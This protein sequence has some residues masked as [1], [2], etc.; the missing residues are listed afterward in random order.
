MRTLSTSRPVRRAVLGAAV[1]TALIVPTGGF[2]AAAAPGNP[3]GGGGPFEILDPQY[4]QNPDT[5]TWDDW[6]AVPGRDWSDPTVTGSERNFDIAL[7]TLDYPDQPFVVTQRP[8]STVFGNPQATASNIPREQVAQFYTDFLNTPNDLNKGHTLHEYWMQ[9]S[10]GRYGVDL[11]GFGPYQL[12][13][14]SYQYGI[15]N[16][17]NPG[18]CPAGEQCARNI[19]TDG[20]GAWRAAV[21]DEV[22]DSYELVFILSA[23]QD[24]SSTWQEFGQMTFQTK[25]DVPDAWGPPDPNLPNWARTRYVEWTSWKAASTIWPNAGGGS[26]T[27]AESSGMGVYAHELSHLLT[28]GDNYNNPYGTPLRRTY[29]GI[30]G[31][32]SRG[33]FNGPGGPHTRWQIPPTNGGAMGSLH[34]V[35]DKI[36]IGLVGEEHILRLSREALASSGIVVADV[37]AR[38]VDAGR[39]GLTG[40]IVAMDRDRS[41][42]C[43]TSADPLCDGGNFNNYTVEVVDRMGADSF[44]PDAG[45]LLSKTKNADSAPFVWV[46]DANPQDIDMVDFYRPDGTP[47]KITM[48]DYRQLSDALFHAGTGSGSEFEYVD[49]ANRLHFYILDLRRDRTGVLSYTVAVRSLDGAGGPSAHGVALTRGTVTTPNSKPTNRGV[50]CSFTLTNT[51]SFSAGGQQH[52]EDV[53]AYLD[54]DVY[55]LSTRAAGVGWRSDLPNALATAEFGQSTTVKV[56]VAAAADAVSTGYIKLTATS[57]SDPTKTRTETCRVDK[58]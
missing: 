44:T 51:G 49:E 1:A 41:P 33:S 52:P 32:M 24:E 38:A 10:N 3:A 55:R 42:A 40:I 5:M 7:V 29:T 16:G 2:S 13:A 28:I 57:V 22:A 35:R 26:S 23:G 21:G 14:K 20:L 27:Q 37:T 19:R 56:S 34:M 58:S 45:V 48:G 53:S 31:M 36:K 9:D 50:T 47:Q 4:W 54:A 46:V 18:A 12:P 15:D 30:W 11:T 8:R 39:N 25:E 43:S 6:V 17:F